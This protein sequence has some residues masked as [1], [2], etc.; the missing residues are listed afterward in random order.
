MA[1]KAEPSSKEEEQI[2]KQRR[3]QDLEA[4]AVAE[5]KASADAS[6]RPSPSLL[7]APNA[8]A[9]MTQVDGPRLSTYEAKESVYVGRS[10]PVAAGGKL[11]VPIQVTSP[12]SVVEYFIEIGKYDLAIT[13]T[14]ERDEGV[15][16]VKKTTRVDSTQSPVTQKFLVGTV[17]CLV[18]F[19]FD[20]GYS[21]LREKVISY[22]VTVTPPSKD[23]LA[24]G[25]Q[26]RAK[27]CLKAVDDDVKSAQQR[28]Q[29]ATQQKG[30]LAKDVE[31]MAKEYAEMKKSLQ[32]ASKEETWL[33]ERVA[34]RKEQQKLLNSRLTNGWNDD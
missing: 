26:R 32:V 15:T 29:A 34:L 13:I 1:P 8:E 10:V 24:A 17:P 3:L 4:R 19:K 20:N 12:G 7:N 16:I 11:E 5:A 25:R 18:N 21:Y 31:R 22:K 23:S 30:K 14:A 2:R 27:S 9:L 28:L 33:K 6:F